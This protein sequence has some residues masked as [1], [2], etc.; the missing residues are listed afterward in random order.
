M[1][2]LRLLQYWRALYG[3]YGRLPSTLA[4]WIARLPCLCLRL[5][6]TLWKTHHRGNLIIYEVI[7]SH[8]YLIHSDL[9][10]F[11]VFVNSS[12]SKQLSHR[13]WDQYLEAMRLFHYIPFFIILPLVDW[14]PANALSF[15]EHSSLPYSHVLVVSFTFHI[16]ID[17][18]TQF[19]VIS[20]GLLLKTGCY[21]C[22]NKPWAAL[23]F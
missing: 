13:I 10:I 5:C 23:A 7:L 4:G 21:A 16:F 6:R 15:R 9:L 8:L 1:K 12:F 11:S 17:S 18:S 22:R 19:K 3:I 14:C 2:S 20:V